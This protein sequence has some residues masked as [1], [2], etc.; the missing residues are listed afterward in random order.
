MPLCHNGNANGVEPGMTSIQNNAVILTAN[1]IS[2]LGAN[3]NVITVELGMTITETV[4]QDAEQYARA[5]K[6]PTNE[7][8]IVL[9]YELKQ[10]RDC[11]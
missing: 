10:K 8:D 11:R 4:A 9:R 6:L 5:M 3:G 7:R 1:P 2:L